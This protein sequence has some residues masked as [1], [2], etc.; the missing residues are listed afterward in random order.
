M[1]RDLSQVLDIVIRRTADLLS[2]P[3]CSIYLYYPDQAELRVVAS[4]QP[5]FI[6][7]SIKEG[8]GLAGRVALS[9][10]QQTV[11]NYVQWEGRTLAFE[12]ERFGPAL[13]TPLNWQGAVLGVISLARHQGGKPFTSDELHLLEQIA[14]Q[15]A[16]ALHQTQLF[17]E[18]RTGHEQL[19]ALSQRLMEAQ[20]TERRYIARELHDEIGQALTLIKI[21]L[22]ALQRL[23][24]FSGLAPRLG[25]SV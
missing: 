15:A 5:K 3:S 10:R 19:Q 13:A 1:E 20:E 25:E 18:V 16:I 23:Q 8:E 24:D 21:N 6:G 9:G 7:I 12:E 17:E 4:L 22:Q 11:A 2:S 14:A